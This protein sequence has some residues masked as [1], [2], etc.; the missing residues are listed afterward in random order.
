MQQA[1]AAEQLASES[2]QRDLSDTRTAKPSKKAA[3][4]RA[5]KAFQHDPRLT[6]SAIALPTPPAPSTLARPFKITVAAKAI[7]GR[8][9]GVQL[10]NTPG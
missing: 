6:Y 9:G 5:P 2:S 3:E 8:C 1:I 10:G 7:R 4:L